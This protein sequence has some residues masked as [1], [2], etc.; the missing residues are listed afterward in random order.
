MNTITKKNKDSTHN[1]CMSMDQKVK[2]L[3]KSDQKVSDPMLN[4]LFKGQKFIDF[5][6]PLQDSIK[7]IKCMSDGKSKL[8]ELYNTEDVVLQQIDLGDI[9][10][11]ARMRDTI[12]MENK[13]NASDEGSLKESGANEKVESIYKKS[14]YFQNLEYPMQAMRNTVQ[15]PQKEE[16]GE[17]ENL[18]NS[19][20]KKMNDKGSQGNSQDLRTNFTSP[21]REP[22]KQVNTDSFKPLDELL[23]LG[24]E[25]YHNIDFIKTL[26]RLKSEQ[27]ERE[28][29]RRYYNNSFVNNVTKKEEEIKADNCLD[30]KFEVIDYGSET[31]S[32]CL[33]KD[34]LNNGTLNI[35]DPVK[36]KDNKSRSIVETR[37][38]Y[39][40]KR[41]PMSEQK[42]SMTNLTKSSISKLDDKSLNSS[43]IKV[44]KNTSISSQRYDNK[45][46]ETLHP[47][48]KVKKRKTI[49]N[50]IKTIAELNKDLLKISTGYKPSASQINS[51]EL[52]NYGSKP[53]F[54]DD[55]KT[56][57][58]SSMSSQTGIPL[59]PTVEID[60]FSDEMVIENNDLVQSG[61][62]PGQ[63]Y[64]VYED[65]D[66][67]LKI[68]DL[69]DTCSLSN[70]ESIKKFF[71]RDSKNEF[72]VNDSSI[73][74][75]NSN[76]NV[77][78][79][80]STCLNN[81]TNDKFKETG[82]FGS[83]NLSKFTNF[84]DMSQQ[85]SKKSLLYNQYASKKNVKK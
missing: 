34:L 42:S 19:Y 22:I 37:N 11:E 52:V 8:S 6:E 10:E 72:A 30:N 49:K 61:L 67:K 69:S 28:S 23:Q 78:Q 62:T 63:L 45:S 80:Q 84:V 41:T 43:N 81:F 31:F 57:V 76:F 47:K 18:F 51:T 82:E 25:E 44:N 74:Q 73:I 26:Q 75:L 59:V 66:F 65:S 38:S 85:H 71:I 55:K 35:N 16:T 60:L 7:P 40:D 53:T 64:P 77:K 83:L 15:T 70:V 46:K 21:A 2:Q 79:N 39:L 56:H 32:V 12:Q 20:L 1:G 14:K 36:N 3:P 48:D 24:D 13:E 33:Y 27:K 9:E 68:E 54:V 4:S 17:K 29:G 58:N 5:Q 50:E